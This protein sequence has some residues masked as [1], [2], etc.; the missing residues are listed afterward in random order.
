MSERTL[1]ANAYVTRICSLVACATMMAC[2]SHHETEEI[3]TDGDSAAQEELS[4]ATLKGKGM[5]APPLPGTDH[6]FL[7]RPEGFDGNKDPELQALLK[8]IGTAHWE[9]VPDG[10]SPGE[11]LE[12]M[13]ETRQNPEAFNYVGMV[14]KQGHYLV[15]VD[16]GA[17]H[18]ALGGATEADAG[19]AEVRGWS[20]GFDSRVRLT[21]TNVKEELGMV[22]SAAGS[23]SGA[24]IG[25]RIVR[26]AAHCVVSHT[27]GGGTVAGS[28]TFDY[29]RD[30][31]SIPATATTSSF[32]YGGAY[33][34]GNCAKSTSGDYW[35]G[36]RNNFNGCTWADWAYLILA[37]NWW[38]AAGQV[39][40]FGY[41]MLGSGDINLEL[42]AGG[43]PGC[44]PAER[45]INGSGCVNQAY[46]RD[47]SAPCKVYTW[48]NGTSKWR[49]GCDI[50]PGNSGGPAWQ[51]GTG[52]LI[53][54]VQWQ[55]CGTCPSGSTN[56]SDP[57]HYLGHDQWLFD[58]QQQL[59][60]DYPG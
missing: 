39:F 40:W 11:V 44:G 22:S 24:L 20:G 3:S 49:S 25:E 37:D 54:H 52:W 29:R 15:Q 34:P 7:S 30:A 46:Y 35:N 57:N 47:T 13:A 38:T 10:T 18:G 45:P 50:S 32:F 33:I 21:G 27:T 14:T 55:D 36:Y 16:T 4:E 42:Q 41:R 58:F 31:T 53:G 56:R 2:G 9:P 59:R 6:T 23:C 1:N 8:S 28:A 5:L 43:Y 12:R 17:L 60:I 51:E 26:T 19:G 48:T